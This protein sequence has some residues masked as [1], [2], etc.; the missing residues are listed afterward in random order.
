MSAPFP[1]LDR[2]AVHN[3]ESLLADARMY[4]L[5]MVSVIEATG[6][7][8]TSHHGQISD[9][10]AEQLIWVGLKLEHFTRR[11]SQAFEAAIEPA[12][13]GGVA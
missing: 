8:R 13:Q 6:M 4:A 1:I 12:A 9:D 2:E 3:L 5:L 7:N 10:E 11:A